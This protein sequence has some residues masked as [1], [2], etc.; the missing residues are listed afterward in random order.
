MKADKPNIQE[1]HAAF[2]HGLVKEKK[3]V[4]L[5]Q[6]IIFIV[7]FALWEVASR[8]EWIDPLIFSSPSKIALLFVEK[9]QDGSL[10]TNVGVTLFETI[11]GFIL[12]TLLGTLLAS[13][14]WWSPFL[15]KVLD[16]YLVCLLYTSPSPRD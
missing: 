15:S 13:I 8:L 5:Y 10:W 2:K 4:R 11:L 3:R 16:P 9:L 7:F 6:A 1:L 14:L 12:G